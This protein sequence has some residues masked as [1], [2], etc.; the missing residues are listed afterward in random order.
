VIEYRP[1]VRRKIAGWSLLGLG[2]VGA[3]LPVLQGVLF[4]ALGLFVLRHQYAWAHRGMIWMHKRW[5]AVVKGVEDAEARL[6]ARIRGWTA[7]CRAL[8]GRP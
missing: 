7:R 5:P 2:V 6:I 4:F 1:S 3:V 8:L